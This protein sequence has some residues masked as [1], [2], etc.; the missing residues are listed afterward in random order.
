MTVLAQ[1]I[2]RIADELFA[3]ADKSPEEMN[4]WANSLNPFE[5]MLAGAIMDR[6]FEMIMAE[7]EPSEAS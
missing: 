5:Q 7:I 4:E 2:K 6:G 1:Q 3:L